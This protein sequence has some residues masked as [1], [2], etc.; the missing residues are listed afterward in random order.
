MSSAVRTPGYRLVLTGASGGLGRAM[1]RALAAR[2]GAMILTGRDTA[3][4]SRFAAELARAHPEVRIETISGDLTEPAVRARLLASAESL[5]EPID[6]LINNA[7]TSDFHAF[8]SQHPDVVEHL[9][10]V[11]LLA[12]MLLTQTLL[13]LLKRAAA[14]Q[15]VNIG[16]VFGYIGYPGFAAYCAAKFGL[17]GFSQALRRE[18]A[19]TRVA[20]RYFAPRATRTR[21]NSAAV[22]ALNRALRTKED[23]P[24]DVAQALLRFL[25]AYAGERALGF[26]ERLYVFLNQLFPKINDGAIR[27]QLPIIH[28]HLP[29]R[30]AAFQ[31]AIKE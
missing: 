28:D 9:L 21:L 16:S 10:T 29:G 27:A 19:D 24:E 25:D 12:P 5:A 17:R 31:S 2:A 1:A 6:L 20:V 4:L 22:T 15:I 18:L 26:P 30:R 8:D 11:D 13:P 3:G 23:A 14:A 7:G